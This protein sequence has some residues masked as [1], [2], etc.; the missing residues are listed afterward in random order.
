[1]RPL[2]RLAGLGGNAALGQFGGDLLES[3]TGSPHGLDVGDDCLLVLVGDECGSVVGYVESV[4]NRAHAE[5]P[6]SN[7]ADDGAERRRPISPELHA[8]LLTTFERTVEGETKVIPVRNINLG[9][10]W[11]DFGLICKRAGVLHHAKPIHNLRKSCIR[12]WADRHPAHVVKEWAGH[13]DLNTTD[14]YYLQVPESEYERAAKMRS[15]SV[16]TQLVTQLA[17]N[18]PRSDEDKKPE[19]S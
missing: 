18:G 5:Q 9:N 14:T 8:M 2:A 11:R 17:N 15:N 19:E 4:G 13:G 12:D 6:P 1:M 3:G 10:L 7:S 16:V